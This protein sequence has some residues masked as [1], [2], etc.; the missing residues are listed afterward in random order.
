MKTTFPLKRAAFLLFLLLNLPPSILFAQGTAFT[1]QGSLTDGA[2]RAN[3]L[4][5]FQFAIYDAISGNALVGAPITNSAVSVSNGLF[6]TT[7]DFGPGVFTGP[8]RWLDISVRSNGIIAF[9]LVTPRQALTA[10]PYAITASNL[11]GTL[12]SSQLSGALSSNQL[13]GA[14]NNAINFTNAAN[15]FAG[16]GSGLTGVNAANSSALGG[17]GPNAFWQTTGNSNIIAGINYLG[18]SDSNAFELRVDN[19]RGLRVEPD[20]RGLNAPNL[21]GGYGGNG[22]L[23]PGSGGN[24][25]IGGGAPGIP[26]LVLPN[27][28][29]VFIGAGSANIIGPGVF[30]SVIVGGFGNSNL[31]SDSVVGGGVYNSVWTNAG[32]SV[33]GGGSGNF[34]DA[35]YSIIAGGSS[36][37]NHGY[38]SV[39]SGGFGNFITTNGSYSVVGGGVYN[40]AGGTGAF[41][42]GG[43]YDNFTVQGNQANGGGSAIV[44]GIGN[45]IFPTATESFIGGGF[46]N[47]IHSNSY[48]AV[49][50]GGQ[51]NLIDT[52]SFYSTI[53]GGFLNI[54]QSNASESVIGGGF[55]NT[56]FAT[57]SFIGGGQ[58]N[59]IG[60]GSSIST[61]GGGAANVI[62]TNAFLATISGGAQNSISNNSQY[63]TIGGGEFNTVGNLFATVPGGYQNAA[64]GFYSF[65]A[66][67]QA[68]ATN[69]GTFVWADSGGTDFASTGPDQFLIRA[70][71]GVG[72]NKN[73]PNSA[74]DVAGSV[75]AS[76]YFGNGGNLTGLS[77]S[78]LTI[79]TLPNG[80]LSGT[81]SNPLTFNNAGNSFT[82]NGSGLTFLN[83]S[84]LTSGTL[85]D[86]RLSSNVALLNR[87]PQTFTGTNIFG[88][89]IVLTNPNTTIQ[90]PATSGANAPM[91]TMFSSGTVNAD[92]M[93]I[94][95]S[96]V[97][98]D[99]GLQYQDTPD[100][101]NFLSGGSAV[102][103]VDLNVE[104]VG[105]RNS[106]PTDVFMV[107]NAH[108][109]GSTWINASDRNL[110]ENF[111]PIDPQQV[112]AKVAAL[113]VS[114]WNYK[115]DAALHL[116]P[117]AQDFFAQFNLG[118][119]DKSIATVDES[120]V[121][122]AAI[123]G[124]NQKLETQAAQLAEKD[125]RIAAL[126]KSVAELKTLITRRTIAN[127]Q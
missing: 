88:N 60:F 114:Q 12:P 83:G 20:P 89:S 115:R 42:G 90:F 1:Y 17:L 47:I 87:N 76:S 3:G 45:N 52:A 40:Q 15:T 80:D 46:Q 33:L 84:S 37:T 38:V 53:G 118:A 21:I 6:T 55:H 54:V 32:Y 27:S 57:V 16:D 11:T 34:V 56:N 104:R 30:D 107:G 106:A 75:T 50:A 4:Y 18:T 39:I 26:N 126:E 7:L 49:I 69:F 35:G 95:H 64:L 121:A 105:I 23:Q 85:N 48:E 24:T 5:D 67:R 73:N 124:L 61:I 122:L 113:P 92:R 41:V 108:C 127:D 51:N 111:T 116:G 66:G 44:G 43:G 28:A 97:F 119:D 125:S 78:Q 36:N 86:A 8:P 2:G 112:L 77:A 25:I 123:Q 101:F 110:K 98:F 70:S 99:W 117:V 65:A 103:T 109:D 81:Y 96:S 100:R 62:G 9:T 10:T 14:Y 94:A 79:G 91:I 82:G 68:K 31:T 59:F 71:G 102:M 19:Y 29:G 63:A 72:I 58:F 93:V 74:L 22:V 13:S 120:G